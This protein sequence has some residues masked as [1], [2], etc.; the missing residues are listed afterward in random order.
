MIGV[1]DCAL[2][3]ERLRQLR[4][5]KLMSQ[6][7]SAA[8]LSELLMWTRS[9]G[10]DWMAKNANSSMWGDMKYRD[11]ALRMANNPN[12]SYG[13]H[14]ASMRAEIRAAKDA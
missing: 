11:L 12:V 2:R 13:V 10:A 7:R 14:V 1:C 6:K 3:N 5:Y 4:S 8:P 9:I